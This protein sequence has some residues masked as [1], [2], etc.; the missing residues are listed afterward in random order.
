MKKLSTVLISLSLLF[1]L[2]VSSNTSVGKSDSQLSVTPTVI[3]ASH[4]IQPPV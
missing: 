1:L 3:Q 4:P 2:S